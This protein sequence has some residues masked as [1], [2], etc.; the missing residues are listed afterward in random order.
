[1]SLI[2][3]DESELTINIDYEKIADR[4]INEALDYEKCPYEVELNLLLNSNENI[5]KINNEY[6]N[7]DSPTD[8]LSFP[9]IEYEKPS[10]FSKLEDSTLDNFNPETGELI[11]GDIIISV[12][13]IVEQAEKYGHSTE[14][15]FAFLVVHSMLHLFGYDHME[16]NDAK[17]MEAKQEEILNKLE[18]FR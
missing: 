10:D 3:E 12:P 11:L 13:K 2:I 16:A 1:M 4:V 14:R 15:E 7:I 17:I 9:M 5:R 18:I 6:R 8:V